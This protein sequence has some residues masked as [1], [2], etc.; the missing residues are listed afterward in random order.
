MSPTGP[1]PALA[2]TGGPGP[3]AA[4]PARG[5]WLRLVTAESPDEDDRALLD[6]RERRRAAALR[7]PADRALYIAVHAELRRVL[8]G[9]LGTAPG[10]VELVRLACPGC[11]GP[12]GR[13]AV[14]GGGVHFSLAHGD[15]LA[16]LGLAAAPI[17]VDVER[18]PAAQLVADASA[19]LHPAERAELAR[20]PEP[21][22]RAAFARCWTRKEAY[23]KATGEGLSGTALHDR[24]LGCG[25]RPE[26]VPGW[27]LTDV[28]VPGGWAAACVVRGSGAATPP[29]RWPAA[30]SGSPVR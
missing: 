27:T 25:P 28:P 22:R 26:P 8:G 16:L 3:A 21:A 6:A 10:A 12:H 4:E 24:R 17:G 30:R 19:A 7:R 20:L 5:P 11:G 1:A 15:G 2:R 29:H 14:A 9:L 23:L 13:P 18:V